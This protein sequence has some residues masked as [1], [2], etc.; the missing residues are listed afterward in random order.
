LIQATDESI[1][2]TGRE[3]ISNSTHNR[4]TITQQHLM[5]IKFTLFREQYY[6][7]K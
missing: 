6:T 3:K 2:F 7:K 1:C 5:H 4:F